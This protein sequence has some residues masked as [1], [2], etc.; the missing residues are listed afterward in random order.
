MSTVDTWWSS[1][2]RKPLVYQESWG[3]TG[4]AG[5]GAEHF[6]AAHAELRPGKRLQA[7]RRDRLFALLTNAVSS[8]FDAG[9]CLFHFAQKSLF[10]II[11]VKKQPLFMTLLTQIAGVR[12]I[13]QAR[14]ESCRFFRGH[15]AT[16]LVRL[17][18]QCL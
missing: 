13:F 3:L 10:E 9:H 16:Q 1:G 4:L 8:L 11:T 17:F 7:F 5:H 2:A 12:R 18:A 14:N 6:L 15:P